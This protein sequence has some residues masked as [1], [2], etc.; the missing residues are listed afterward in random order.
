[1]SAIIMRLTYPRADVFSIKGLQG[2]KEERVEGPL[3]PIG[4]TGDSPPHRRR[5]STDFEQTPPSHN[6][7]RAAEC[8]AHSK[9]ISTLTQELL[10]AM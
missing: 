9:H 6:A 7:E 4:V 3:L 2:S 1:M 10:P 8:Q 5:R